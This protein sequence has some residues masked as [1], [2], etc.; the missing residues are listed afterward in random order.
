MCG[1]SLLYITYEKHGFRLALPGLLIVLAGM[2]EFS[3]NTMSV[4]LT[5][6]PALLYILAFTGMYGMYAM[7]LP[8]IVFVQK[9]TKTEDRLFLSVLRWILE[10]A[11]LGSLF[12]QLAGIVPFTRSLYCLLI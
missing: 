2:W 4:Y 7:L 8:L 9:F 5:H 10:A 12:L 1:L 6:R 11:V 3:E